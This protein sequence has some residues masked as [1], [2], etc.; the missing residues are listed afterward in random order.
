MPTLLV[1]TPHPDDEAYAFGGTIALAAKAGWRCIV[2]CASAGER[3]KRHD[4]G[5][6]DAE[7]VGT[8]RLAELA[9]SCRALGA[10]PPATWGLP[11][12][13]L[14]KE[15]SQAARISALFSAIEPD[16]VLTL[17]ADGA[18]GHPDHIAVYEWVLE[19]W[20]ASPGLRPPL[21]FAAFPRGL[22]LP[23]YEKCIGMMGMPPYPRP[24]AIG[25]QPVHYGVPTLSVV[26]HKLSAVESH[27]SQLPLGASSMF[28]GNIIDAL[29]RIERYSDATGEPQI[30]VA[31]LL[32]AIQ[33]GD[34]I[35]ESL[36]NIGKNSANWLR[37]VGIRTPADLCAAG[38]D[39][40]YL[41]VKSS[42]PEK[43]TPNLYY[44]L[45]GA[46]FGLR[47]DHMAKAELQILRESLPR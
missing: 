7:S 15:P 14:A 11:D 47:W 33:P 34:Y 43:A 4:G 42:F 18:Y 31:R 46:I 27:R 20:E 32:H 40:A 38:P 1:I 44:S 25:G 36:V 45:Y 37:Q 3:G 12:G 17:G 30:E 26:P 29:W 23:Q 21:L 8:V 41:G 16:L 39:E 22:F 6:T 5:P 13:D 2:Q 19:A 28:P 35:L 10:Q 24:E 9:A